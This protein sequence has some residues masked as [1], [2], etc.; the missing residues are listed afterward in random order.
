MRYGKAGIAYFSDGH[1]E[2]IITYSTYP[3][4]G[5]E[6]VDFM[7]ISGEYSYIVE[8]VPLFIDD[9]PLRR[10]RHSFYERGTNQLVDITRIELFS[11]EKEA[12]EEL[13]NAT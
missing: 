13:A 11:N 9:I 10:G 7:T 5:W 1:T 2:E 6:C 8:A 12:K 4:N 3:R